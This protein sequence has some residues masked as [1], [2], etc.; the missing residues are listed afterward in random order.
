[1]TKILV[2]TQLALREF[3]RLALLLV[4]A[5]GGGS[6]RAA[7]DSYDFCAYRNEIVSTSYASLKETLLNFGAHVYFEDAPYVDKS[8]PKTP[9]NYLSHYNVNGEENASVALIASGP[10][11]PYRANVWIDVYEVV[12]T[13]SPPDSTRVIISG[14]AP[15]ISIYVNH[16]I[17]CIKPLKTPPDIIIG[18]FNG[19]GNTQKAAL[20][21]L[22]RLKEEFG[23]Q[24]KNAAL[25]YDWFYNQTACGEAWYSKISCLED[26]SE[27]FAQ[28]TLELDGV[29]ANRWETFWE[30]LAGRHLQEDSFTGRLLS[31]L[32]NGSNAL[33]QW[34]DATSNAL[35][36]QLVRDTLKLLTLF[37]DSPTYENRANHLKR[38]FKYAD[39][40]SAKLLVAHSQGNLF[41]NSAFDGLL[42]FKPETSAQVVHVAPASPTLR[43][44]Y[45]LADIDLVING[46]RATGI[47]SV[48]DV[49][50]KLPTSSADPSGHGFDPTYLDKGRASHSRVRGMITTSLDA[51]VQ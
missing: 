28:R 16:A 13:D 20:K 45:V 19:V 27:T 22:D 30:M 51:L 1:M 33:L 38:L 7:D 26:V 32:G 34:T 35:I 11:T 14:T 39:E 17:F 23:P 49:N 29:F 21:S 50:I 46:L 18:F 40:G 9:Q 42:A 10:A 41:V 8:T 31:L 47:N 43:G 24:Y 37:T 44:D 48:P 5:L 12:R 15:D 6:A 2:P 3:R 25:K 36:N 4:L